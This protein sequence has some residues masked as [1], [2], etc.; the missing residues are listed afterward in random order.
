M[1]TGY[2]DYRIK[3]ARDNYESY[4]SGISNITF[5]GEKYRLKYDEVPFDI[6]KIA[7][8]KYFKI[9]YD[10]GYERFKFETTISYYTYSKDYIINRENILHM[11]TFGIVI[12]LVSLIFWVT[13][14]KKQDGRRIPIHTILM[15]ALTY[16]LVISTAYTFG[17]KFIYIYESGYNIIYFTLFPILG[18]VKFVNLCYSRKDTKSVAALV[19]S[20]IY[21]FITLFFY[22]AA[23]DATPFLVLFQYITL[24]VE[25]VTVTKNRHN[26][27]RAWALITLQEMMFIYLHYNHENSAMIPLYEFERSPGP[28]LVVFM[29]IF[30]VVIFILACTIKHVE[31]SKA[32]AIQSCTTEIDQNVSL[33]HGIP[34]MNYENPNPFD[35]NNVGYA[36]PQFA[37][38]V[39]PQTGYAQPVGNEYFNAGNNAQMPNGGLY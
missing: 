26:L 8:E 5:K 16:I 23:P 22:V 19:M 1:G 17:D 36:Q 4:S 6:E 27:L 30:S 18:F 11:R 24:I 37:Q 14:M 32:P 13:L 15:N 34:Q 20:V 29:G 39:M 21:Y 35:N 12:F 2:V 3:K 7:L 33:T 10:E 28:L 31:E 9:S 38:P 25:H